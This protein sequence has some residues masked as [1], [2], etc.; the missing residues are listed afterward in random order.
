[1]LT[2]GTSLVSMTQVNIFDVEYAMGAPGSQSDSGWYTQLITG[3]DVP[4][5]RVDFC[6]VVAYAPDSSSYN[7]HMYG[8][9]YYHNPPAPTSPRSDV[10]PKRLTSLFALFR[11]IGWD[12]V[13]TEYFDY[14][15]VL[16]IPSFTW[17]KVN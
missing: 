5:P 15:W 17:I 9:W 3:E 4:T 1:M 16:S 7:I 2:C 8:G 13:Q 14:I 11:A 6:V 10:D 12:P